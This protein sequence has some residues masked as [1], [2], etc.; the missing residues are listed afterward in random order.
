[1]KILL[2]IPGRLG[3]ALPSAHGLILE[4]QDQVP[5]RA[6]CMETASPSAYLS[7]SL[8]LSVFHE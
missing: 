5:H 1:M 8:S 3:S 2:G 4:S 6:P 7:V